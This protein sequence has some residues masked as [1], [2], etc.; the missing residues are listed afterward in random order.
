MGAA[1]KRDRLK[2]MIAG[3]DLT[4]KAL[5]ALEEACHAARYIQPD[6]T[7]A[8]RFALAYLYA[9]GKGDATPFY[10][11]WAELGSDNPAFRFQN[12]DRALER[13]YERVGI[14]RDHETTMA[15]WKL[16]HEKYATK[17][18]QRAT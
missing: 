18:G 2:L 4:A 7:H 16:A 17:P 6:R 15:M 1:R 5:L 9:L 14:R 11:F 10:S 13:I 8:V 3:A 12:A